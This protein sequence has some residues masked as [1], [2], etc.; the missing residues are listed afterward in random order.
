MHKNENYIMDEAL[1]QTVLSEIKNLINSI[2]DVQDEKWQLHD[3]ILNLE[4][5]YLML[6]D[7]N[8]YLERNYTLHQVMKL[9]N[10]LKLLNQ[11]HEAL[12]LSSSGQLG[13]SQ[14][15]I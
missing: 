7:Q 12:V 11:E 8:T 1:V 13:S 6:P 14:N 4:S 15:Q 5:K 3:E 2:S 10:S 9:E